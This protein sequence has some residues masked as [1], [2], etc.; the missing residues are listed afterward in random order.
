MLPTALKPLFVVLFLSS[1]FAAC[2]A[3]GDEV[4]PVADAGSDVTQDRGRQT[5]PD[6]SSEPDE[7]TTDQAPE[8]VTERELAGECEPFDA[9]CTDD[10][11]AIQRCS[12]DGRL[13]D[14][15]I[16]GEEMICEEGA[17]GP[18][19]VDCVPGENCPDP[20][21]FCEPNRPFCLDFETAAQCTAEG[22]VGNTSSCAPG[23]CFG[24]GCMTSGNETGEAC[25]ND[26]GCH[27]RK[28]VCG[29]E[30]VA[31]NDTAL[32]DGNM[33]AGYCTT[34]SCHLNGCDPDAEICADFTLSSS[35][36]DDAF[37]VLSEDCSE[38]LGD[39]RVNH[40]GDDHICRALPV[41]NSEGTERTWGLGC[42][43]PPPADVDDVCSDSDCLSPIGGACTGNSDCVGGLCLKDGDMS[44][45]TALCSDEL[46]CPDHTACV[47]MNEASAHYCMARAN[48][49]DC[50]RLNTNFDIVSTPLA[51]LSGTSTVVVCFFR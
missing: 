10:G 30:D 39:C 27:G 22:I 33:A 46:G 40:R 25:S 11:L 28:C 23:R 32:C 34:G 9:H 16:C 47:R 36:G 29:T 26:E 44:Y 14:P 37:C 8:D 48:D 18:Q 24:G 35:F 3:G 21:L 50:P 5:Q 4:T 42:W 49:E 45:C 2:A 41:S 7:G 13:F 43:V 20:D 38:R 12:G 15:A 51:D 17:R 1:L 31:N 6:T 19:C